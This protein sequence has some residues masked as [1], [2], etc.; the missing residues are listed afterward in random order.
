MA[1]R[2]EYPT[3]SRLFMNLAPLQLADYFLTDLS[4]KANPDYDSSQ[5]VDD[6]VESLVVTPQYALT[7]DD[8]NQGSQWLVSLE[9]SQTIPERAN[10]PYAFSLRIQGTV[11]ASPHL[12]GARLQRSM[13]ANGPAML[14]GAAREI[15]RAATGRGPWPAVIIPSTN[16][17]DGLPPLDSKAATA[18]PAEPTVPKKRR[19]AK[20]A[21]KRHK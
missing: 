9:I 20:K 14:Y 10:L 12:T 3:G 16:F 17:F 19:T 8:G 5:P 2:P 11:F 7:K 6:C 21:A 4:L 18:P 15:I 13:H 1:P